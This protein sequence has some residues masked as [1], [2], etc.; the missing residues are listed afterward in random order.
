MPLEGFKDTIRQ[1]R[2]RRPQPV[3]CPRCK[4]KNMR[5]VPNY[6]IL[7]LTYLCS[8]C[9]YEGPLVIELEADDEG[10][11]RKEPRENHHG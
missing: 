4:G 3:F 10:S 8:D 1:L 11:E 7:P 2:Y 5:L 9:G 6:G